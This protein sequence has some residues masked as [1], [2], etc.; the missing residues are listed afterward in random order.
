M[1]IPG[2]GCVADWVCVPAG[3][4]K[5]GVSHFK[6]SGVRAIHFAV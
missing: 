5:H 3:A 2:D 6:G 4:K 1:V